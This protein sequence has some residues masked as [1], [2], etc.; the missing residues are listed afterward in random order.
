MSPCCLLPSSCC[1]T[2]VKVSLRVWIDTTRSGC[3]S[4][5]AFR[6]SRRTKLPSDRIRLQPK[7]TPFGPNQSAPARFAPCPGYRTVGTRRALAA[8]RAPQETA[9]TQASR[10]E[11]RPHLNDSQQMHLCRLTSVR[12]GT[13]I[14]SSIPRALSSD[15]WGLGGVIGRG[16][17][18]ALS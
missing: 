9:G 16:T 6:C 11:P 14:T 12:R 3:R 15:N 18:Q 10:C 7:H 13:S 4:A 1:S 5:L 2:L 17:V 8:S